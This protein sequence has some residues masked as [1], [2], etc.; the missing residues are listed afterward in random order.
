[1]TKDL[2]YNPM[3]Y[4]ECPTLADLRGARE[5]LTRARERLLEGWC[6]RALARDGAGNVA[7]VREE[8]AVAWCAYGA[9]AWANPEP[10]PRQYAVAALRRVCGSEKIDLAVVNDHPKMTQ[11]KMAALFARA[12]RVIENHPNWEPPK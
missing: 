6:Q 1:M 8:S 2:L 12:I 3:F 5:L 4:G 9:L 10:R 7:G 11:Q